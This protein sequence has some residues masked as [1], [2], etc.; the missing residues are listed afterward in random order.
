[1]NLEQQVRAVLRDELEAVLR[2]VIPELLK[3]VGHPENSNGVELVTL[4]TAAKMASIGYT[5]IR[6]LVHAGTLPVVGEGRM[7]RVRVRDLAAALQGGVPG[8]HRVVR[9]PEEQ[10]AAIL[11]RGRAKALRR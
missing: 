5:T 11:D 8:Q 2:A 4:K 10:A 7:K 6:R 3:G 1:M 9:S